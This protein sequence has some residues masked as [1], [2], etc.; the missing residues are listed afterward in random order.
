MIVRQASRPHDHQVKWSD[1]GRLARCASAETAPVDL[2][3]ARD[4]MMVRQKMRTLT[5]RQVRLLLQIQLEL[6]RPL[7]RRLRLRARRRAHREEE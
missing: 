6:H 4:F 5:I 7:W 3:S 1:Q 2:V